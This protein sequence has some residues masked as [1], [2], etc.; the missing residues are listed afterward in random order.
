MSTSCTCGLP[1]RARRR[2]LGSQGA[3]SLIF[4]IGISIC[5]L[6]SRTKQKLRVQYAKTYHGVRM[7]TCRVVIHSHIFVSMLLRKV[8][9]RLLR[10][11]MRRPAAPGC[12]SWHHLDKRIIHL[13]FHT[14]ATC[15]T[16]APDTSF[17]KRLNRRKRYPA[18]A[19][20]LL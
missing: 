4:K 17:Y 19:N 16:A 14:A 2:Y 7:K 9:A 13:E 12:G 5:G 3:G 6:A 10:L 11:I 20:L 15:I 1:C 8:R 18:Q